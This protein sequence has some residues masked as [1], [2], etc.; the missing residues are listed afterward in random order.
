MPLCIRFPMISVCIV[1]A[2]ALGVGP[3]IYSGQQK[4]RNFANSF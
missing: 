4:V 1:G 2:S 3:C